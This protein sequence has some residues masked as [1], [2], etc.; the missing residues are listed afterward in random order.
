MTREEKNIYHREWYKKNKEIHKARVAKNTKEHRKRN[1][2]FILDYLKVNTCPCG[3]TDPA[4]L[5]FDHLDRKTKVCNVS[6]MVSSGAS[7][8]ERIKKEVA[9]CQVLCANC[10][11]K[12]T[13]KE[14]GWYK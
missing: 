12:K 4:A 7:S 2:E 9:K 3:E 11:R 14:F 13:A 6:K 5:D 1:L 10:H 8:L